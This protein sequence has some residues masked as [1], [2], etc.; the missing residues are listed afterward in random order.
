MIHNTAEIKSTHIGDGTDIWQFVVILEE[1]VIGKYCNIN[2]HVFI[3][4]DVIVGNH[5]TVKSGVQL[6]DGLRIHDHV[7]IGPNVTFTNDK[8]PRSK[9]YP[10]RFQETIIHEHASIGAGAVILGG[11]QIGAYSLVG[12]GSVVTKNV[13]ERALVAGTPAKITGWV[14]EDGSRMEA[15]QNGHWIDDKGH[16]WIQKENKLVSI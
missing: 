1:A 7:F 6:W 15:D 2:A 12:A 4:N 14:N 5:V 13:P 10:D 11:R 9:K 8:N 16:K 3:E